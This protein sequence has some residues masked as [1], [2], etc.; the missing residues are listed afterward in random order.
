MQEKSLLI[1]CLKRIMANSKKIDQAMKEIF[2]ELLSLTPKELTNK[3]KEQGMW[4]CE[5]GMWTCEKCGTHYL[6]SATKCNCKKFCIVTEDGEQTIVFADDK[7]SA[8]LNYAEKSNNEN[9]QYLI[10]S[11]EDILVNG[12]AFRIGAEAD[13]SYLADEL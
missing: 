13:I 3:I 2:K 5:K 6:D 7:E 1:E 9:D 4:T 12:N 8:A 11:Q 10:D